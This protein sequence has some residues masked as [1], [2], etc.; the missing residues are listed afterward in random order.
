MNSIGADRAAQER[1]DGVSNRI[2]ASQVPTWKRLLDCTL[3]L[4]T[5]PFWLPL[6]ILIAVWVKLVS[7]GPALFRQERIGHLGARFRCLKFRTMKVNADTTVHREHLNDLMTSNRPMKKL[8]ST[9]DSRLIPGGLWLRSLGIDELPQLINVLR[10]DMSLVGPRPSTPY[11]Y[12]LFQPCHRRRCE[13]LPGLT[14]LW[15]VSGKN[16]TTFEKMMELDVTYCETKSLLLDAKIIIFTPFAILRQ[17]WDVR[18]SRKSA[19]Q[20]SPDQTVLMVR[21]KSNGG[22]RSPV[23]LESTR[24][25]TRGAVLTS[26]H[27]TG[28]R[29][30]P[31]TTEI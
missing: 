26:A 7:P 30:A 20:V 3:I 19:A 2:A 16:R 9:G 23:M 13:S 5:M 28:L 29:A 6:G 25:L 17:V 12:E 14:G 4:L 22:S 24:D 8:D 1:V 31:G 10:G 15:Q 27:R 11:E 18:T 21:L